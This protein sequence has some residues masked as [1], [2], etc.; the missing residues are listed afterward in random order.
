[1]KH[2]ERDPDFPANPVEKQFVNSIKRLARKLDEGNVPGAWEQWF[3]WTEAQQSQ[4]LVRLSCILDVS[5]HLTPG[6]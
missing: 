1:M 6:N 2:R 5:F 3:S 4:Y